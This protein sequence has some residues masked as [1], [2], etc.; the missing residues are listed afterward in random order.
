V[1]LT[2][3]QIGRPPKTDEDILIFDVPDEVLKRAAVTDGRIVT[4]I[5]C[6]DPVSCGAVPGHAARRIAVNIAKLRS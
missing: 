3:K 4:L 2:E 5:Y 6:T 1:L